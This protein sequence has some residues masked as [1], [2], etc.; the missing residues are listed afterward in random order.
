MIGALFL[1]GAVVWLW[2]DAKRKER[3]RQENEDAWRYVH[4]GPRHKVDGWEHYGPKERCILC[5]GSES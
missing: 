4:F 5:S 1:I 2:L 3:E